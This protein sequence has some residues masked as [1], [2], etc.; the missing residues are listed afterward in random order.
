MSEKK[1]NEPMMV[2]LKPE[3]IR[4]VKAEALRRAQQRG[5]VVASTSEVVQEA[6]E[7][8]LPKQS[9]RGKR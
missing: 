2:R 7:A 4:A 6:L 5:E 8:W 3:T 9:K 1:G